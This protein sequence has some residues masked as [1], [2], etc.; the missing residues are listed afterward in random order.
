MAV[1]NCH[2]WLACVFKTHFMHCLHT[3][4]PRL[5]SYGGILT[6]T[7]LYV[8]FFPLSFTMTFFQLVKISQSSEKKRMRGKKQHKFDW[9]RKMWKFLCSKTNAMAYIIRCNNVW[10]FVLANKSRRFVLFTVHFRWTTEM[11]F[12]FYGSCYISSAHEFWMPWWMGVELPFTESIQ[13]LNAFF[14]PCHRHKLMSEMVGSG[15]C[16][17]CEIAFRLCFIMER[18]LKFMAEKLVQWRACGF[19]DVSFVDGNQCSQFS[20]FNWSDGICICI[21]HI[22]NATCIRLYWRSYNGTLR[23]QSQLDSLWIYSLTFPFA[24]MLYF[25][26]QWNEYHRHIALVCASPKAKARQLIGSGLLCSSLSRCVHAK[27]S[28]F[29]V[30]CFSSPFVNW[31]LIEQFV[32]CMY[33]KR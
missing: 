23:M 28:L 13:R 29:A 33:C 6:V 12:I 7:V 17:M 30:C 22:C 25:K 8:C 31:F 11:S 18:K 1:V 15:E 21:G 24:A 16:F 5:S 32:S 9:P 20:R 4:L 27:G 2:S 14:Q 19:D 3:A 10:N 26:W